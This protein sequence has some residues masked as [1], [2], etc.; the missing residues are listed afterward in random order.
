MN[1]SG[2]HALALAGEP[3]AARSDSAEAYDWTRLAIDAAGLGTWELNP[4]T[5]QRRWSARCLELFGLESDDDLT[6]DRFIQAIHP[7]DRERW[8]AAIAR[9]LNPNSGADGEYRIEYRTNGVTPRWIASTGRALFEDGRAVRLIGTV[10]DIS[11]RKE[12][13]RE[14]EI[15]LGAL[16]H[17][18]R[19]PLTTIMIHS[20][21]LQ[22][23]GG[24][25]SAEPVGRI[26]AS[27]K[28][29]TRMI[30][31]LVDFA[32]SRTG[33]LL[34][35][36]APVDLAELCRE[37]LYEVGLPHPTR[38]IELSHLGDTRGEWDADRIAQ[39]VQNLADNA[40][41]HGDPASAIEVSAVDLGDAVRIS[42]KNRGEP[43]RPE[44]RAHLF[45]P[46]QRGKT[47]RGT[48]LGLYI[49]KEIVSAHGGTIDYTSDAGETV[50]YTELPRR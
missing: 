24:P 37:V 20:V 47:G 12:A 17:D 5:G 1:H 34:L 49:A 3:D 50:F 46:F 14:R 8:Q 25:A 36:R 30:D 11:E 9:A 13:E 38:K 44:L 19:A 29:M 35:E 26:M 42:V 18:L 10:Q 31:D 4:E 48:G 43:I 45:D 27:T 40:I 16:G 41:A 2:I 39:V 23:R 7:D 28:R 15:F 21:L 33:R 22:R 32:R 6:P